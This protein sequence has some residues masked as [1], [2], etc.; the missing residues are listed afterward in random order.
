MAEA[1]RTAFAK[2]QVSVLL[3]EREN[4]SV[5][6]HSL[7]AR[8]FNLSNAL[9]T[10]GTFNTDHLTACHIAL[11]A[12]DAEGKA[13]CSSPVVK[14]NIQHILDVLVDKT[15]RI[16]AGIHNRD[17]YKHLQALCHITSAEPLTKDLLAR[18]GLLLSDGSFPKGLLLHP[19]TGN[20]SN[21]AARWYL[22]RVS[23]KA[24]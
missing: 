3:V 18:N 10:L 21:T 16:K 4:L 12:T 19:I 1:R 2:A 13:Y 9:N 14:K 7:N 24:L 15:G 6:A 22:D 23:H 8:T 11:E 20:H 5:D 17:S